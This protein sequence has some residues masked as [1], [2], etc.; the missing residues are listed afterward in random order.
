M[1]HFVVD[2]LDTVHLAKVLQQLER[3]EGVIQT[4]RMRRG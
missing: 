1:F 3:V 4:R 2:V